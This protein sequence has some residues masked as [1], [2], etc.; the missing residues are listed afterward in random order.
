MPHRKSTFLLGLRQGQAICEQNKETSFEHDLAQVWRKRNFI[1]RKNHLG[2]Q[3]KKQGILISP[4]VENQKKRQHWSRSG[5]ERVEH[6]GV[7]CVPSDPEASILPRGGWDKAA[8][9]I[10][11]LGAIPGPTS[12]REQIIAIFVK[13]LWAWPVPFIDPPSDQF[14]AELFHP[15]MRLGATGGVMDAGL[16]TELIYLLNSLPLFRQQKQCEAR[17]S[18][19]ARTPNVLY[20]ST[21]KLLASTLFTLYRLGSSGQNSRLR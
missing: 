12:F 4:H 1:W 2:G 14:T 18:V 10:Q 16:P 20:R 6:L 15:Q 11:K 13:P 17:S 7:T 8:A 21:C 9:A 3:F 5:G 19:G